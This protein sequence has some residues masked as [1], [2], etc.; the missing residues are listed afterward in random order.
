MTTIA[1][2]PLVTQ[3]RARFAQMGWP[4][5]VVRSLAASGVRAWAVGGLVR[6]LAFGR[7]SG[8]LDLVVE[9][10]A[11]AAGRRL[12]MELG[13][14]F[15]LLDEARGV[16][17]VVLAGG[18]TLDIA[19]L[20]GG[21]IEADLAERDFTIDAIAI[22]V[23]GA[24]AGDLTDVCG[25]RA[26]V[27]ARTLRLVS[28]SGFRDDGARLLRAA[29]LGV[30]L[31]L[32]FAPALLG[33]ARRDARRVLDAA[34]ERTNDE[35]MRIFASN[36][37]ARGIRTLEKMGVLEHL[38]PELAAGRGVAQPPEHYYDVF[39]H[40][41]EAVAAIEALISPVAPTGSALLRPRLEYWRW[42]DQFVD[43]HAYF[44][45]EVAAGHSRG[46]LTKFAAL[47]HDI[48]KPQTKAP[49]ATGR[50]RFPGHAEQGAA[51]AE[52]LLLRLRFSNREIAFVRTLVLHHLRPTQMSDGGPPT[53]RAVGRFFR[54]LGDAA[55]ALFTLSIA[56]HMAARG[57]RLDARDFGRH[58]V[59]VGYVLDR[60]RV[61][62]ATTPRAPL[63]T[64][65]DLMREL[66]LMPGPAVGRVLRMLED[67]Q[68][69][70]DVRTREQALALARESLPP[71]R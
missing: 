34:A 36:H 50:I 47:L 17:R 70:G 41:L 38:L 22:G 48:A 16:A 23:S 39:E 66:G 64:G 44:D 18:A 52:A 61:M 12:A 31:G 8:D 33:Q 46:A 68:I 3:L 25:G 30:E 37:A 10:D 19:T 15:V 29:R 55:V 60:R 43:V 49:D 26:D 5:A 35:L 57:P 42:L 1:H 27:A 14:T 21:S 28:G 51:Q 32:T 67:A 63:V 2:D 24:G 58:V 11:L 7:D 4:D 71:S 54:D 40:N 62:R 9:G 45:G 56:D 69:A 20:R 59:Y 6:D 13:G 65:D 53:D